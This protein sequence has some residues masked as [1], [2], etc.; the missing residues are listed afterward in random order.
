[1]KN[2]IPS[3]V[4]G[5]SLYEINTIG[6]KTDTERRQRKKILCHRLIHF[7]NQS[8]DQ[9]RIQSNQTKSRSNKPVLRTIRIQNL[10]EETDQLRP[11]VREN[12]PKST[13]VP[14]E[15][16]ERQRVAINL[17][18]CFHESRD[19]EERRNWSQGRLGGDG[20]HSVSFGLER[21]K[22]E[23]EW[24]RELLHVRA[25]C[26]LKRDALILGQQCACFRSN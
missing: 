24:Q 2:A 8:I 17:G 22:E 4:R 23:R 21:E 6:A 26:L 19:S 20:R 18:F 1:M 16:R 5:L 10:R 12:F 3:D 14:Q 25:A 7:I 9:T 11:R 13:I 15:R